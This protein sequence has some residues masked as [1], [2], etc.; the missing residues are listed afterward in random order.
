MTYLS[1][2]YG[3]LTIVS[4]P[5]KKG[6]RA[7]KFIQATCECGSG[8]KEYWLSSIKRGHT[9]SCGCLHK[10]GLIKRLTKHGLIS[11]NKNLYYV[12]VEMKKRCYNPNNV[13]YEY[14]GGLGVTVCDEWRNDFQSFYNWS[15]AN[16]YERGLQIDRFPNKNGNYEPSNSRWVTQKANRRNTRDIKLSEFRAK[17]IIIL[18]KFSGKNKTE[19][20]RL[21]GVTPQTINLVLKNR[22]WA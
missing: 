15:I 10:E 5:F 16:G 21:Y 9:K 8:E 20:A 2:K 19:I 18:Y 11:S 22:I 4:A 6:N 12:W 1:N 3:R 14:C 17:H 13:G 7:D